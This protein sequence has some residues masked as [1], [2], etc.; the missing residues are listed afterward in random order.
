VRAKGVWLPS[1][2]PAAVSGG[3]GVVAASSGFTVTAA[4]FQKRS[5]W[6]YFYVGG[7]LTT[8]RAAV[9]TANLTLATITDTRFFPMGGINYGAV[10]TSAVALGQVFGAGATI[11]LQ[12]NAAA[13]AA[14]GSI[15]LT[16]VYVAG[17]GNR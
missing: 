10:G 9:T 13:I 1:D 12:W 3:A 5:G 8:A 17:N 14:G 11:I 2:F 16:G 15:N 6:V 7:T 4:S